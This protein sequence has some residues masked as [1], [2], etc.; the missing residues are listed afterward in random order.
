MIFIIKNKLQQMK[1]FKY[2]II[3]L[4]TIPF[5]CLFSCENKELYSLENINNNINNY[6]TSK[7]EYIIVPTNKICVARIGNDTLS[8]TD[9]SKDILVP[10]SISPTIEYFDTNSITRSESIKNK[11]SNKDSYWE[12]IAFEDSKSGDNDY[13]DLIIHVKYTITQVKNNK[14]FSL[15]I[16]P[17]AYGAQKV[18]GLG[19]EVYQN[20]DVNPIA[21]G[22]IDNTRNTLFLDNSTS[23]INTENYQRHYDG[24]T[25]S[26][27]EHQIK[28][29]SLTTISVIWYII[30]DNGQ[31]IYA[32]NKSLI[33]SEEMF[34]PTT[35]YPY[36]LVLSGVNPNGYIQDNNIKCG[37]DWFRY[38][39]EKLSI[40]MC[41]NMAEWIAS[42]NDCLENHFTNGGI[43]KNKTFDVMNNNNPSGRRIY[44][45]S[46]PFHKVTT[47]E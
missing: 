3:V 21:A 24:Y 17:I 16:H 14:L 13:N 9:E 23:F 44:E 45:V 11:L 10:K 39:K 26:D 43:R 18:I 31:K 12:V 36:S 22:E 29:N 38:P 20:G 42:K 28:G 40:N 1:I 6:I 7:A 33:K 32:I 25:Y 46:V 27:I 5:Y 47:F 2:I 30:V 37:F 19:Y 35:G 15:F 34:N 8:I 4:I 41:Y